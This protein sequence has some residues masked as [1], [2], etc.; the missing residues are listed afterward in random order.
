MAIVDEAI[1]AGEDYNY[2][3]TFDGTE[4]GLKKV[5]KGSKDIEVQFK[6]RRKG[7]SIKELF[8]SA[9]KRVQ[10]KIK[11]ANPKWKSMLA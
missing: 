3:K 4:A 2:Y 6:G 10:E 8:R 1:L 11:L 5:Q 7:I 9:P